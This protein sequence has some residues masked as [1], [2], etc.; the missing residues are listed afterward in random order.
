VRALGLFDEDFRRGGQNAE[1]AKP[2]RLGDSWCVAPSRERNGLGD[3]ELPIQCPLALAQ[4]GLERGNVLR[5]ARVVW[6]VALHI[7]H[8]HPAARACE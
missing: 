2:R 1:S 4:D 5:L 3:C 8:G 7:G 6:R